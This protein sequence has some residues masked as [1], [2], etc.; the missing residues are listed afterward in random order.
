MSDLYT[1]FRICDIIDN[2]IIMT[3]GNT[4]QAGDIHSYLKIAS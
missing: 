1:I 3:V 2:L 4:E